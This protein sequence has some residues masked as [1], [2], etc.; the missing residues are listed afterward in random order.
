MLKKISAGLFLFLSSAAAL[1]AGPADLYYWAGSRLYLGGQLEL[2]IPYY[3][4]V[5]QEEPQNWKAYQA[6]GGIEYRLGEIDKT[7]ENF[8][9]SLSLNPNNLELAQYLTILTSHPVNPSPTLDQLALTASYY[10]A[11]NRLYLEGQYLLALPYYQ[12][13]VKDRPQSSEAYQALG[14]DEYR[15]GRFD[16]AIG[17]YKQSLQIKPDNP[18]LIDFLKNLINRNVPKDASSNAPMPMTGAQ[19]LPSNAPL[20][21][22][23][24]AMAENVPASSSIPPPP[25]PANA[26]VPT[27]VPSV[28]PTAMPI[29]A[30]PASSTATPAP[31]SI[32][33]KPTSSITV[34]PS[35]AK[36]EDD[37][38]PHQGSMTWEL[39]AAA[40]FYGYQDLGTFTSDTVNPPTGV[41]LEVEIDLGGDYTV[42]QSLQIGAQL[43]YLAKQNE[44]VF[45][46]YL[47]NIGGSAVTATSTSTWSESCAGAVVDA[48]YLF[49]LDHDFRLMLD[50]Q[51]G[52]YSL[53]NSTFI[54]QGQI[55]QDLELS[56]S[57]L[58]GSF[59]AQLEWI[60]DPGKFAL[61]FGLG[62]R[63]LSFS[64]LTTSAVNLSGQAQI[65]SGASV[66]F[67][68]LRINVTARFF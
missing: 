49:P 66:D 59:S 16:D 42:I 31:T 62:Y 61:D 3:E 32:P 4:A 2:A 64:F 39:G 10:R 55:Y 13:V 23:P 63:A 65:N 52:F 54:Y 30:A 37:R 36:T 20:P 1:W 22:P 7:I 58:G 51:G 41:P 17:H 67:S 6:L 40:N 33:V 15:M 45:A 35:Q 29:Q 24:A 47:A 12:A 44:V 43:Q 5:I 21:P 53:L 25:T 14:G 38:L 57:A 68:G 26:P 46:N 18:P 9:T 48:K 19:V 56:S 27:P 34:L 8:K 50:A 11:A 60:V 28:K